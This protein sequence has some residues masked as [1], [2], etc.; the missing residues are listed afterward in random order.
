MEV[1]FLVV[2]GTICDCEDYDL[3]ADWGEAHLD[4]V[5]RHRPDHH[6]ISGSRRRP[7][8]MNRIA[9]VPFSAAFTSWVR[10]TWP[11]WPDLVAIGGKT[12]WPSHARAT[13]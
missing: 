8:L 13:G 2:F 6:G 7:I 12:S 11:D 4:F 1:L 5:R 9:P 3:I 10:E